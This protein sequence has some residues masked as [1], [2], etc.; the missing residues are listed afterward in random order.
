MYPVYCSDKCLKYI[1]DSQ[2]KKKQNNNTPVKIIN[3]QPSRNGVI[4][5]KL[6]NSINN[7][8][9]VPKLLNNKKSND[10]LL[11]NK[12]SNDKESNNVKS[13]D[14]TYKILEKDTKDEPRAWFNLSLFKKYFY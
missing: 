13:D 7:D 8:K 14:K 3:N 11:N 12:E 9:H 4:G 1:I 5:K 10:K 2:K 6:N